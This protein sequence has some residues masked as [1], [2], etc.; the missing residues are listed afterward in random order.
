MFIMTLLTNCH[1]NA[2]CGFEGSWFSTWNIRVERRLENTG[3]QAENHGWG[4]VLV[5]F[6]TA[7]ISIPSANASLFRYRE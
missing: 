4:V 2:S 7:L 1:G 3:L 5:H 6:I